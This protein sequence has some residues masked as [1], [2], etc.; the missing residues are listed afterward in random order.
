MFGKNQKVWHIRFIINIKIESEFIA[1]NE[2]DKN[3]QKAIL[4]AGSNILS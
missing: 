2:K 4:L 1:V 3:F